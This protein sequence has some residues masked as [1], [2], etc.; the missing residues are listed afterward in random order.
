MELPLLRDRHAF[1]LSALAK[2]KERNGVLFRRDMKRLGIS[3]NTM[4]DLRRWGWAVKDEFGGTNYQL[5]H[6]GTQKLRE[7]GYEPAEFVV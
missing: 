3:H 6:R 7:E 1:A 2:A 5:S 4:K